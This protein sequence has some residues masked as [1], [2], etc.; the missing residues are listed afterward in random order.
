MR[1][2]IRNQ[3]G[4]AMLM[5]MVAMTV[6]A[7][8]VG[9]LVYLSGV[10]SSVVFK[11]RDGLRATLMART[12][13]RMAML[14]LVATKKAKAKA[15]SMGMGDN[16]AAIDK[17][18]Q[19]PMYLPPP[20][21]PGLSGSDQ[22]TINEFKKSLGFDSDAS[23]VATI[24]GSNNRMS[25]NGLVWPDATGTPTTAAGTAAAG[26]ATGGVVQPIPGQPGQGAGQMTPEQK[27]QQMD[28]IRKSFVEVFDGILDKK[29]E[30]DDKFREKYA[31]LKGETLVGNLVAWMDPA[32][33]EDGEGRGK[34]EYYSSLATPYS[35][36]DQPITSESEYNMIK[37]FDDT[38]TKIVTD[39]FSIQATN[40]LN[41][42]KASMLLISGLIPELTPD[43][44]ERIEKRRSDSTMGGEFKDAADFWAY[45]GTLGS[46]DDAKKK[47]EE[48]GFKILEPESSYRIVIQAEAGMS[49]KTWVAEVGQLPPKVDATP[50]APGTAQPVAPA[51]PAQ[52]TGTSTSTNTS[53]DTSDTDS[54]NVLYLKA[55]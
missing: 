21:I 36:K 26:V 25:I 12:G 29:R 51:P 42:N 41:V 35:L 48:K 45:V 47:F 19:T 43:A 37:G 17:I 5:A 9:E 31:N 11:E 23:V 52:G 22:G 28:T 54:L 44:L 33:K 18:W 7:I 53:T 6:I 3:R 15:K 55:D 50:A 13:L 38:I 49:K 39:N 40:S 2:T 8:L 10:Y 20:E 4:V 30:S 1:R 24:M 27:K 32:T 14:Q 34:T 16:V 46:Y